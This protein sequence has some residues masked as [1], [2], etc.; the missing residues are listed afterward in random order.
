MAA[1]S[2]AALTGPGAPGQQPQ[3]MPK[4]FQAE[5]ENLDLTQ[6]IW[7]LDD[8]ENRLLAKYNKL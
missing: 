6:H 3:D 7:H 8:V 5:R 1:M 2:G 4:L